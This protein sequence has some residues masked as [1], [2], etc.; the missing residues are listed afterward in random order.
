MARK[1][2]IENPWIG[3]EE[4]VRARLKDAI[5]NPNFVGLHWRVQ[6]GCMSRAYGGGRVNKTSLGKLIAEITGRCYSRTTLDNWLQDPGQVDPD[7][8]ELL[9]RLLGFESAEHVRTGLNQLE[10]D[11]LEN[12]YRLTNGYLEEARGYLA[13]LWEE[14]EE[15]RESALETLRSLAMAAHDCPKQGAAY[16]A[17]AQAEG[18]AARE[19]LDNVRK[20][21]GGTTRGIPGEWYA[22]LEC[23]EMREE[24][25][26][27]FEAEYKEWTVDE[28]H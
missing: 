6:V 23:I 21:L 22:R 18:L 2:N 1:R 8:A 13:M 5:E 11:R 4:Q 3:Y 15:A 20:A 17:L 14:G 26:E 9:S 12:E 24:E 7:M 28:E 27:M 16:L 19:R 10:R 25:D